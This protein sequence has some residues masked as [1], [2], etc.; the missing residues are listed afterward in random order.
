MISFC[1]IFISASVFQQ[2]WI[3]ISIIA[4]SNHLCSSWSEFLQTLSQPPFIKCSVF[5]M[6]QRP[7]CTSPLTLSA[8]TL[9]PLDLTFSSWW[10]ESD[11]PTKPQI[12]KL[13]EFSSFVPCDGEGGL[14]TWLVLSPDLST[15]SLATSVSK[16]SYGNNVV[17]N[18]STTQS[19]G[20]LSPN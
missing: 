2:L 6:T 7:T 19:F 16:S 13:D 11:H 14:F 18:V 8:M 15:D 5:C 17:Q 3:I 10:H 12:L 20:L 1:I 9:S 4:L